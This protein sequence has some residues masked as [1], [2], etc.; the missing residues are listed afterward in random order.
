MS[1]TDPL[2]PLSA[3]G[4][5]AA[6]EMSLERC[7]ADAGEPAAVCQPVAERS[8]GIAVEPSS[9]TDAEV[10]AALRDLDPPERVGLPAARLYRPTENLLVLH[11][12]R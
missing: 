7:G 10:K 8:P 6:V 12:G 5:H 9:G 2:E 11:G 1:R 3:P 4:S